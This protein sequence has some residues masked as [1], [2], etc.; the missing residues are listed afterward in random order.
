V[1]SPGAIEP[2]TL[3][4]TCNLNYMGQDGLDQLARVVRQSK[5]YRLVFGDLTDAVTTL[6]R[7][8]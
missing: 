7:L 2:V 4:G 6:D 1:P 8:G 3:T 5:C